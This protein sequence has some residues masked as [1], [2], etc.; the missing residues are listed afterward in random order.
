[1]SLTVQCPKCGGTEHKPALDFRRPSITAFLL[2]GF[3]LM[4]LNSARRKQKLRCASCKEV[5]YSHTEGSVVFQ[6][7]FIGFIVLSLLGTVFM[8]MGWH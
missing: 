3:V 5:F 7:I 2:G 4:F 6:V 8:I 1:M